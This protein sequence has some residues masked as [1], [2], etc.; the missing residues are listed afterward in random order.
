MSL[1]ACAVALVL[2]FDV[3]ASI[4]EPQM[5]LQQQATA[6]AL[7]SEDIVRIVERT[8]DGVALQAAAFGS[9]PEAISPWVHVRNREDLGVVARYIVEYQRGDDISM[10]T[11][12][13]RAVRF[14]A[15]Q[16]Q[17]LPCVA[18]EHVIDVSTDGETATPPMREARDEAEALGIRINAISMVGGFQLTEYL[19]ENLITQ[20][21]FIIEG[22]NAAAFQRA[23]RRKLALELAAR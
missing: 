22:Y 19:R 10:N 14:A 3:S 13:G 7:V 21:G 2:L 16:F 18:D 8:P 15:N 20:N 9:W 12:T 17:S 6:Q 1:P 5:Q 11:M 4:T 23:I